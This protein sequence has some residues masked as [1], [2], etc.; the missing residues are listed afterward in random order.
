MR[1]SILCLAALFLAYASINP[2]AAQQRGNRP[3]PALVGDEIVQEIASETAAV[4]GRFVSTRGGAVAARISGAVDAVSVEVGERVEAGQILAELATDRL[5]AEVQRRNALLELTKARIQTAKTT[6]KLAEQSLN[7]LE[8]LRNSAAFSEALLSDKQLEAERAAA[9]VK[10]VEADYA[11]AL[12]ELQLA[13]V[14]LEYSQVKAPYSGVVAERHTEVGGFVSIGA[15]VVTLIGD[16]ALEIEVEA[17]TDRMGGVQPGAKAT[18]TYGAASGEISVR[19]VLPR[20]TGVSRTRTVRFGPLPK[21]IAKLAITNA[22]VTINIPVAA[23]E[24]VVTIHKDAIIRRPSG[25]VAV[26]AKPNEAEPGL[27]NAEIKPVELGAAI[28]RR[29]ILIEGASPGDIAVVRGN[30]TLRPNQTFKLV[31]NQPAGKSNR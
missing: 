21:E 29:F 28:G 16:K 20:E 6:Q 8:R 10:E 12:A 31:G 27:F 7:R 25:A 13:K 15:P 4:V 19:A 1:Y 23:P 22:A 3:P 9:Q 14:D 5:S 18:V 30:E 11:R 17:P 2:A 26:F 24:P